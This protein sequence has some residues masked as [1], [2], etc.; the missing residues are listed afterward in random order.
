MLGYYRNAIIGLLQLIQKSQNSIFDDTL[1]WK[2]VQ[3][4]LIKRISRCEDKIRNLKKRYKEINIIRKNPNNKISK[5]ES[6][7]LK[8]ELSRIDY[9]LGEYHFL[10]RIFK[11]IGNSIA[12][13]FIHK[14]DIKPQNF[15]ESSGFITQK[16][17]FIKEKKVFRKIFK[18]GGIAIL[19]DLTSSLK[20]C[21][22]TLITEDG[23]VPIEI[24][25]SKNNNNK[26]VLRQKSN[27]EKIF[28]YLTEDKIEELYD[29]KTT[30][31]RISLKTNEE[32]YIK[33]INLL[34][35]ESKE[36]GVASKL[37][38]EGVLYFVA[39]SD[40]NN[41]EILSK[42][43]QVNKLDKPVAFIVNHMKLNEL[44]YYPFS[45]SISNPENYF[46]FIAG[47]FVIAICIDYDVIQKIATENKFVFRETND[48]DMPFE[49]K[50]DK[51]VK[52]P[53]VESI[54]ISNHL[55]TRVFTEF[56]SLNWLIADS[57]RSFQ[58]KL[59]ITY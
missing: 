30:M 39:H 4:K 7:L 5:E 44:G 56:T 36:N 24:K 34:I 53:T 41:F 19:N 10:I 11:D 58:E 33:D 18:K 22:I 37:V 57:L 51:E 47:N 9:L 15:K 3:E 50:V 2:N 52:N 48:C 31:H 25:S 13:T 40:P 43:L 1:V 28:K 27:A 21:D 45:L 29:I 8:R 59:P 16:D 12:F 6:I 54:L 35:E 20:Y 49:F 14:Y 23:Y 42:Q 32:N 17:G 26:R 55:F 46:D 38:E